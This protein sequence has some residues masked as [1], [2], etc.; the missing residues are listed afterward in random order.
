[1]IIRNKLF[2]LSRSLCAG[3]PPEFLDPSFT[4]AAIFDTLIGHT[5]CFVS[6]QESLKSIERINCAVLQSRNRDKHET[7][8]RSA[9]FTL[10][11][12]LDQLTHHVHFLQMNGN[13]SCPKRRRSWR[14]NSD[15]FL[16]NI[17]FVEAHANWR[18]LHGLRKS[19]LQCLNDSDGW[20][21]ARFV[22]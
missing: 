16:G 21:L 12:R 14:N 9:S 19:I 6:R 3:T 1:M 5:N 10:T 8:S 20:L 11:V 15:S 2:N 4:R 13:S 17:E 22:G 18:N 7:C